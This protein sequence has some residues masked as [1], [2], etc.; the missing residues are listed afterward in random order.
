MTINYVWTDAVTAHID[1]DDLEL[2]RAAINIALI[3]NGKRRPMWDDGDK[4]TDISVIQMEAMDTLLS[5]LDDL[6]LAR[7]N[8]EQQR[9]YNLE[10]ASSGAE[11]R[12]GGSESRL[13]S[14]C[15]V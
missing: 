7:W 13:D 8:E 1:R 2:L 9:I 12:S 3:H 4:M 10:K 14:I 15:D 6:I 11:E 5:G